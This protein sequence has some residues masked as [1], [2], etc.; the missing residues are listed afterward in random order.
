MSNRL[1]PDQARHY[2][3]PGLDPNCLQRISAEDNNF[4][5]YMKGR[6]ETYVSSILGSNIFSGL[7]FFF[8]ITRNGC[9]LSHDSS[10]RHTKSFSV[11]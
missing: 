9:F 3:G 5:E 4:S 7:G 1:E 11:V 2:V 8:C 6:E 10:H